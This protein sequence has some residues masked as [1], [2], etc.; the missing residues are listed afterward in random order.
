MKKL[1][2][3]HATS[4]LKRSRFSFVKV[5]SLA[6]AAT[7]LSNVTPV[8]SANSDFRN[9]FLE[10]VKSAGVSYP[11]GIVSVA[12]LNASSVSKNN[13]LT[14]LNKV[15]AEKVKASSDYANFLIRTL[16]SKSE[17]NSFA[18]PALE[19]SYKS[20]GLDND[21]TTFNMGSQSIVS[22]S[23]MTRANRGPAGSNTVVLGTGA[24]TKMQHSIAIGYNAMTM[25]EV[26]EI[27][28][29]S[30]AKT[31][32]SGGIALG[33]ESEAFIPGGI[34]AYRPLGVSPAANFSAWR[35]TEG[36][37]SIGTAGAS[38][39]RQIVGVAGGT[40]DTDAVNV[41][42]LKA[43]EK[44]A[45]SWKL[46]VG[47]AN[48]T[49]VESN[50][51][52]DLTAVSNNIKVTKGK[53]DNK[54]K[55][56]LSRSVIVDKIQTG[57]NILDAKGLIISG[58]P[59][60]ATTGIDAGGKK[61][62][63]VAKG[64]GETDVV[65]FSQLKAVQ[66][67][68]VLK[69]LKINT[70]A[71]DFKDPTAA[72]ENSIAIGNNANASGGLSVA[73]GADATASKIDSIAIGHN[74]QALGVNSIAIGNKYNAGTSFTKA[75]GDFSTVVGDFA[76]AGADYA[77]AFGTG[78]DALGQFS[79]SMGYKAK[80]SGVSSIAI[81]GNASATGGNGIAIGPFAKVS[82]EGGVAIG[83]SSVSD[84]AA[85]EFGY[86]SLLQGPATN[87]ETQWKSTRGAVSVGDRS[88]GITRQITGVAAG[89]K[90]ADAVN[91]RQLQ[92][93]E[94][95]VRKHGW[96][97]SVGGENAKDVLMDS[98]V[99]FSAESSNLKITKGKDDNKVK[100]DL[101]QDVTLTSLK[102][103]TNTLDA[104]GLVISGGPKIATDG[105][106]AGSKKITG[107]A[108]GIND[109][110]A[111]NKAQLD[112]DVT[113]LSDKIEDVRSAAVLY[114]EE[115]AG[116]EE[117]K[118]L[119]RS[120]RKKQTSVT[121]GNPNEGT[122]ALH[123]VGPGKLTADSKDA[124]NGSQLFE[125]NS[126]VA[127]YF[128]GGAGYENG[129]WTAPTFKV[130]IVNEDGTKVEDKDYSSVSAAFEGVGASFT[131]IHNEIKNAITK[132]E[133]DSLV[134]QDKDA[135]PIT[136]GKETGGSVI[137][138]ANNNKED[139]TL[140][141][142]KEATKDNEAV[143]K[144]QLDKGLKDLS[145]SL[146]SDESA[147]VHYDKTGDKTDYT[148]VTLGGKDKTAVGLH[149]V[150]NG[151]IA[152][153]SRDAV[154]G[155]QIH[156]IGED[157]AK[158]LGGESSFKDGLLT[159]PTYKLSH[160]GTD[161]DVSDSSFEGIGTA[162]SGLDTNI[163]N[164]NQR[165]K[166][167]SEGVAHDSLLWNDEA[168]AF[169]A[170]HGENKDSSK[171][172]FLKD[173]DIAESSTDAV[174]GSQL[175]SM[176]KTVA[177]Y[178]GGGA[179]YDEA[180]EWRAPSFKVTTVKDD[181]N[182]EEK[183]YNNVAE[184][185]ADVGTSFT[186][187]KNEITNVKGDSLVKFDEKANLIKIGGEK[188]G[189]AINIA[190]KDKQNRTLSGVKEA[191]RDDEAVNKGQL[192]KNV[193]KLSDEIQEVRSAAVFYDYDEE[194]EADEI[195]PLMRSVRKKQTSVTFGNPKEGTVALRNVGPG[196]LTT[197]STEAI[198]GSQLFDT[199]DKI[200]TYLGGGAGYK[201]GTWSAPQF[202]VKKFDSDGS[203]TD[204]TYDNV[205]S[206]FAGVG[207]SIT[208]IEKSFT[209]VKN[210]IT[211]QI[212]NAKSDSL[213]W[214]ETDKAFVAKH[215]KEGKVSSKI[216]SLQAGDI[217]SSS[218][219]AINGSQ[220]FETNDKV[221]TYLGG[222]ATFKEGSFT[223]P[224]YNISNIADD[225]TVTTTPYN[226]VGS[227]F[228][229]LDASVKNVNTHLTNEVKN[230][231]EK[232]TNIT[233]EVQGDALLWDKTKG[234]FV[235]LHGDK[236]SK[237]NSKIT[238]LAAGSI[239]SGSSDA[240]NGGQLHTITDD[241]SKILGGTVSFDGENFK[242]PK[243]DLSTVSKE[244]NVTDKSYEGVETAFKGLDDNIKNVNARIKEVSEGVAQDSL[245]WSKA[246]GAFV[247]QHGKDGAKTNSKIKFLANGDIGEA[248]T[249]AVNGSQLH[250]LGTEVAK[251]LG[252]GASYE[253]GQWTAP[254][255]KVKIVNEDGTKVEDKDYSSV[256]AAFE[257][258]GASF[259]NIHNE[260]KNAITKVEGDSLVKQDKDADPITIGK[261]TGGSVINIAN[262]SKEDRTLSGVKE[263]MND[264][265]AVNKGQL[266]K[267]LK[268][269]SDNLQSDDS[270]V[271]HY[272]KTGDKTD[273]TSVT[274]G[275]KDKTAVG[276]HNVAN[277]QIA[278]HSRDAV[279]G[280]QLF[281]TNNKVSTYL[282]GGAK[283]ENGQWVS[284]T[285]KLKTVKADG[286]EL[287]DESYNDVASAFEG[288]G[289]S[290]T[291]ITNE[292][293]KEITNVK[294]NSLVKQGQDTD[295]ITIGKETGGNIISLQNKSNENRTLSGVA[296]GKLSKDS[297]EA[298][299]GSQLY[300]MGE[301]VSKYLGGD[302]SFEN[303]SFTA[304]TYKLSHVDADGQVE[305]KNF[306]DV[307]TA[308]K[309][310][311]DNIKTVN[312]RIKEV[313]QGVA[314]DS[315]SWSKEKQAF[316]A[317]HG[318][319]G[320]E[321]TNSKITSLAA[322]SIASGSSDA[323]NGGQLH[324]ITDD[325]SK[326]LG[327]TVSF[328]GENFKGPKYE[329]S[330][331]SKDGKV[332]DKTYEDVGTAFSGL[333]TN[334]KNVN[335]RIK[336]VSESVAQDSL[337]WSE[338]EG[339]FVAQHGKDGAKTNSKIKF[340]AN[341][342]IGEDSTDAVTGGQLY[343]MNKTVASYFG[344]GA[345]YNDKG[346]WAAPSFKLKTINSDGTPGEE[347]SYDNV[348]DA[349]ADVSSSF[350]NIKNEI[351]NVVSDSLVKQDAETKVIKIGGEKD[352]TSISIANKD[353]KSRTL[354]GV[355]EA[356]RDDEAVN[357]GQ[358][359]K[360][361]TKL[362]DEIQEVRS[363]AVFYDYDEEAEA[364][365]INPLMRSVRKKQTSVTF[366]NPKEGTVG[367]HNVGNGNIAEDSHDAINGSQLFETNDKVATY[368]GGGATF[369][370]GSFTAPTYNI[371]N[372][373]DDGTATEK[374]YNDVGSAFA[375]LDASVKN[376]NTH[377][378]NEVKNF[379][380]KLTNITQEVQGDALL[381]DKTKGAFVALHGDKE[382]KTNSKITSLAAGSI[383]SGS[384]DAVNGG[385]LH[386]ITDDLSKILGG[387]VSFD[388]ENFKGLKYELS[389]VSKDGKVDDK[390]YE[391]VGTAF[392]GLD[393]NIKNVNQR[394]KD[395]SESVAQD[396]LNWS[397]DEG[398]FVAQHGK[399]GAKTNSKI[400]FL[401]NGDIGEDSTDA[402]NGSQLHTLGTEVA[403]YLGGNA[404]YENGQWTDPIF[405]VKQIGSDG[406]VDEETY[407]NVADAL[408][409][410]G[411]SF[412]NIHDEINTMISDSLVKQEDKTNR[413]TVGAETDGAEINIANKS[414][415]DRILSGVKEAMNDNEAVNKGQ[416]DKSLKDL[417]DNL[418]SDDSA[419]VHYDK[420]G[421]KTDYT[422]V[423]LGGKDKTAVGLHN[424]ADGSISKDSH[425]AITGG[426]LYTLGS[427]VAKSLGG[428]A[429]YE[430]GK[431]VAPS[432]KV[433][434]VKEDGSSI[435][436]NSYDDVVSAFAGV[437]TSF[438]NLQKEI[439]QG[440]TEVTENIKQNALLWS[441]DA[442]A[443]VALHGEKGGEKTNSK[444]TSL[445]DGTI[446]SGSSDAV[447][448]GQI[449][450][451]NQTLAKYFGGETKYENDEWSEPT[452]TLKTYNADG[453]E[454]DPQE[455]HNVT[456][457]F[458]GIDKNVQNIV[459]DFND[460]VTNIT[461]SVQGDALLWSD[462]AGAFV[463]K[464]GD[465][466]GEKTNSKITSLADGT[467]AS[468]SSDAVNGG[469]L[470]T[471]TDDLSKILGGTV[472]FDGENFKGP[473]Y[474]LSTVS[475]DGKVDDK[476]YEDVGT[477]FSGLD[478]N[479]KNVN[480]R[481]K[482]VSESV[483]QDSL[484]WSEDE[485]AFVAQHGKDGAKTNSKIKFLANGDIGE[486]STDAVNGSQL[487]TLGTEVA[488]YLGGNAKYESGQWTDP[489]FKVK[490]IGSDGDVDEETYNNVADALSGVGSSFKNIHDEINTMISDSLV[491]QE[492]KTNRI[493]VG[494]E[495]DGAE[496]NIA[497]K[498]KGDRILSGVKEAMNDN[499]AVN[500]GQLDK[501]L[502][503]LSDNLQSDESAVVHYDKTGDKTDY[504]S[505]TLGGKDKTAVGLHNVADGSISK[506]SHDAI[507]GGQLYTLG[508][509]VAKSLG[510]A[511]SYESGKWV[512]PSFKL[513]TVKED[514]SSIEENSYDDVVSA[515]AGVGTSFENLQKEITQGNTEV[516]ENIKQNA[517]LW[518]DDAG[519]FV[520][521]HGEKGGEKT[522]SKI[523]SLADGTIASGSSDAV[524]GGQIYSLNQTLAK[525]FGGETKYEND[526]WSE[527]TFTLKT[528][529]ADGTEGDPQEHHNVTEAFA[530]IDKNVQNIVK[531]FNDKV[532][533]ITES[534][535]GDALLWS[536]DAG[537]F[538]AKHG[539]KDGEKTNSKIT[540]LAD[541]TIAS[542]S[543]D[544]VNGGQIYSL[545]Q[546]LA[547][548]FGGDA[549]YADGEW[550]LPG[551]KIMTF[552][553][554]GSFEEE[555]YDSIAAAF[556]GVNKVFK[557][558]HNE[559]SDNIEQNAL[560]W[561]D[562]A[563]AFVAL[564]G[565]KDGEK[566]NSKIT[567]LSE[568]KISEDSTDAING[569][570][571]YTLKQTFASY[572]GGGAG[573]DKEGNW[574]A[575]KFYV[576]SFNDDGTKGDK[577]E[578]ESVSEAFDVVNDSMSTINDRIKEVEK[579]VA[580]NGLNWNEEEGSYDA[581]H[582]DDQ[583]VKRPSKIVNVE[584]GKVDK[585]SKDAVNGG[586][587]WETQQMITDQVKDIE[588]KVTE[589][590]VQ[591]DK[592]ETGK[593]TNKVTLVGGDESSPVLI[594]NVADGK[595]ENGSKEAV[596]GGQLHDYTE[597]QMKTVLEDAK[598]YTDEQVSHLVKD[599]VSE[600]N[601]YTDM[602]FETLNYAV[603]DVR[604]EARQAAAIGLAVSNL[605]Y[606]DIPGSLSVSFGTG[607]WRSQSAF[608]IGAGYTSEDG[609]IR[610][611][612]SI[613]S[614]G[615]HWGVG[616]GITL[617]LR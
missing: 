534:V 418:Q 151:Q 533:N 18:I 332:D 462:D 128:G 43:L 370:E 242:G 463:A 94:E 106:D 425:D 99:D 325:L 586:Q 449:Y 544:A 220:L 73:L 175:Y 314:Q 328:D 212:T 287:A 211:N 61:I 209:N 448:G 49:T 204:S 601:S 591:Y 237:T 141:G 159:Q 194:A 402:V 34:D 279:N 188:E 42:Q 404:K 222:G 285:F 446:A 383:V 608:A 459:K 221:A 411:S 218:T 511:A 277:G 155:G 295:P 428:A 529:N 219:D 241:L 484:N 347:K 491:K 25:N 190:D 238:S 4:E 125:T 269:L 549:K 399:D 494:A 477:A 458:A 342:D 311:D 542:G 5:L 365:E 592:D 330:T 415:G 500:K 270:A 80:A 292:L 71:K 47:G 548:Y 558:L 113:D 526:E 421:D 58:G 358:L 130:K 276:L 163:K 85:G 617:R 516:T 453:T 340:L 327:G 335:Q 147:V 75:T 62:T 467:I 97:L 336:D 261:E 525:Y 478:T 366:G 324:T 614:A 510:G 393:T 605:R 248:S 571:I 461:E 598:K 176:N 63:G 158:F 16:S 412:K 596:N 14:A 457:A 177:T 120:V 207:D 299:N 278:E 283:Y 259:T 519:A 310:L 423:T 487:H 606:Y 313:S 53:D 564:H 374:S 96:K 74:A 329:L 496:I 263:A 217:T 22:M 473:K 98:D 72:A 371:S 102:A 528:Y 197:D 267:S 258:V 577:E 180:G 234:A 246:E 206:A 247:A 442:G 65:N 54:V 430:S 545:N 182:S 590:S 216:T 565:E 64:T 101:A 83:S 275:G 538:V 354:S 502:K 397:E 464:H 189:S 226:D 474:E 136:I 282:G 578:R 363:A 470:H 52:V 172:T 602:K 575:P 124:V 70:S 112:K 469:Q 450:S 503:D 343:S 486:D 377:L 585:D 39:T 307:G 507:T 95:V 499:E 13:Y 185:L 541:G 88:N 232:L 30:L 203:V 345:G 607:L 572:F 427:S 380:E 444:I 67:A 154:N 66:E 376:V 228:A 193:T 82:G 420:T 613:T 3:P 480:Q 280:S 413:I 561:S 593:K 349:F 23:A 523:T 550:S 468:G 557:N 202:T 257:G 552:Q 60:I 432:F 512:A 536:D 395:V 12:G 501:S 167:V 196:K 48:T 362:S 271:V 254:T 153:N 323:I 547:K 46:S 481:I 243:Y 337:N 281:E 460:K 181:G 532:T 265:E 610:S 338:D 452:F 495:T 396:S 492:D 582:A 599:G 305:K 198:N 51:L 117:V 589:G 334:I 187:I 424:V 381:W 555:D 170:T 143:N 298:V 409:G 493:T 322:G 539:E 392:S 569:G 490:Q 597:Q 10:G 290:F 520:A 573:Y 266:D 382:S 253:N 384:S 408:S 505:V 579:D 326:I 485:G 367:L 104:T 518:S 431:W 294:S 357:K 615:G 587:L 551:F 245:N 2:A 92:D 361:V 249:D 1:Y 389:T 372:I 489:I 584:D 509:S 456:E 482:D 40:A 320:G 225:G 455:H 255:F 321:K 149:N 398:V 256:S 119:T 317:L 303:G 530:G 76:T 288:V 201:E 105:I 135:D 333:D 84:R 405:K 9:A 171:L 233:Q 33:V 603:E 27:A 191:E 231:N 38:K 559:I 215:G 436:E 240:V 339:A 93:L 111:V 138:I 260:I 465:K 375:G 144:G 348:A 87:T 268:D 20:T 50:K 394:I 546:S 116:T 475:K 78:S 250:T 556:A 331:V 341:G 44:A 161:G 103:G 302:A 483:A 378:T 131:N 157:I 123:N 416:L 497:N 91:L 419:V 273:Y 55:F 445:A 160:I 498:N 407:N 89:S 110:D 594:N 301:E 137:N 433:K 537:A 213:N 563:G 364:D 515:F 15:G 252:G 319:K 304:P 164:V 108:T 121:F 414:K 21:I 169:V 289:T 214:S 400:K 168:N 8:F 443:F 223:A 316:V 527:P 581:S 200:A 156:K 24:Q 86:T 297:H 570:Q 312:D 560:L 315:L 81:G 179:G 57:N 429:S 129:Q 122:V 79:I 386:T 562:D 284:P 291:N 451:L 574:Q 441:D 479:I 504:T 488:K 406:D 435:E 173:G 262:K 466:D 152:E 611:N 356:E 508:S 387:T 514:G 162:F 568:G 388:G 369:K 567:F 77:A 11:Q 118:G 604:K 616:A 114:D 385:Q 583:G 609:N 230:F 235:A 59:K 139:R 26:R 308:F 554:D 543:S 186:N 134:K 69:G 264:N 6:I 28:I 31:I 506:D 410:V 351:T 109:T 210:E 454:G 368:L 476:T 344:G 178:F 440:N 437:G 145:N 195:N 56:D 403:K 447:N 199:N 224:T 373:A 244:G 588:T 166:E 360:N 296:G 174:N 7:F 350:T 471:I 352:G 379:N 359:D 318:D 306:T 540:S 353:S 90:P 472:S 227:A 32:V 205:A 391:D 293:K 566:T 36:A 439:T 576:Q 595:I 309:G 229:G 390:T 146:Q 45:G 286:A 553:E 17:N 272:D 37:L 133:G 19:S 612:V 107:V 513:K 127:T 115:E 438:E 132:V 274:L 300:S 355:K 580:S 517:L 522:N 192:D 126:K 208:N 434:T 239:A 150:A 531:D 142:V 183:S 35:S 426:Q 524:N 140:S 148:S 346:E 165:I 236:E 100:F 600:A 68:L 401:A 417:S 535:Q 521:L 251:Y 29:G 422:S 41:A 184:A